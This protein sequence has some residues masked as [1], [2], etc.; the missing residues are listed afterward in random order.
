MLEL[1]GL[2]FQ[3][4]DAS[5][6]VDVEVELTE[7][8][9][10]A[11]PHFMKVVNESGVHVMDF[12]DNGLHLKPVKIKSIEDK[13]PP[14][15]NTKKQYDKD[16]GD[17]VETNKKIIDN[18]GLE[19]DAPPYSD[20]DVRRAKETL[21]RKKSKL[22]K[23]KTTSD[24]SKKE[25][26]DAEYEELMRR[27]K[28]KEAGEKMMGKLSHL[29]LALER[30]AET[31]TVFAKGEFSSDEAEE[32]YGLDAMRDMEMKLPPKIR[33]AARTRIKELNAS[34]DQ[35]DN[36]GY[37]DGAG[38]NSIKEK[39]IEAIEQILD[40][41]STGD[42]EG[43]AQ[44]Q[45]FFLTLMNPIQA[46]IPNSLVNFLSTGGDDSVESS[47]TGEITTEVQPYET[48]LRESSSTPLAQLLEEAKKKKKEKRGKAMTHV[49]KAMRWSVIK[50]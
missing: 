16:G 35:Y 48:K 24:L 7:D 1:S 13:T 32:Y 8:E 42:Y 34:I 12:G 46:L 4:K 44:A 15:L 18:E 20:D 38:A 22:L 50:R 27:K 29:S 19:E 17:A 49:G 23:A 14:K 6:T 41:L 5:V 40:N 11:L 28:E 39:A 3:A 30:A 21:E 45:Q 31:A 33:A 26:E 2:N 47:Y 25:R 36:K 9:W 37:N 43:F 10:Y